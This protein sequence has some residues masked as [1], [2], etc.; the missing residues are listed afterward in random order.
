MAALR[1]LIPLFLFLILPGGCSTAFT[2]M[3][4]ISRYTNIAVYRLNRDEYPSSSD[5][6]EELPPMKEFPLLSQDNIRGLLEVFVY[7]QENIWGISEQKVFYPEELDR[8]VPVIHRAIRSLKEKDQLVVLSRHDPDLSV[9]S[10][11]ERV[12]FLMWADEA[13]FNIL[14][15][16]IR[17]EIPINDPLDHN[18]W[19]RILPIPMREAYPDL[20]LV[21]GKE[22]PFELKTILGK[23]HRT[24]AVLPVETA[25]SMEPV[26]PESNAEETT[27][28]SPGEQGL[29]EK[30]ADLEKA[31]EKGLITEEEYEKLR[32]EALEEF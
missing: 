11:H 23:L 19:T 17:E 1:K 14:F 15:G 9:L 5:L 10:R 12:T 6:K 25:L 4:S 21:H 29:T 8:I 26:E 2:Q 27:E 24:W 3:E 22:A 13:G 7:K 16:E 28:G 18:D 31:K 30:L 20:A 32:K